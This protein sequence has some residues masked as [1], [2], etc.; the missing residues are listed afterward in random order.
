MNKKYYPI[1]ICS[2]AIS[3]ILG[4]THILDNKGIPLE[5]FQ[6]KNGQYFPEKVENFFTSTKLYYKDYPTL[7]EASSELRIIEVKKLVENK[8]NFNESNLSWSADGLYLGYEVTSNT[9]R[10][11]LLKD[12]SGNFQETLFIMPKKKNSFLDGILEKSIQ[13][14][15]ASLKWSKDSTRFAFMSNGGTGEYNIYVG[16]VGVK[17]DIIAKSPTKEG[18]PSW[19]PVRNEIAFVSSRSGNGD[20]YNISLDSGKVHRLSF[21]DEVDI[22]PEW[23]PDGNKVIY[24]SGESLNHDLKVSVYDQ[25]NN[26]WK[27]PIKLTN[28]EGD[29]LR[30]TISPDGR[31]IAFYSSGDRSQNN[32]KQWNIYVVPF[33][34]RPYTKLELDKMVVAKNV[35]VDL[36]T[37]PAW[38]PDSKKIFYV[39]KNPLKFNPIF[40][41]DLYTGKRFL[42]D[43]KTKMNR[44]LL[45]SRIGIISFRA[46][47]G[48]WDK[49]FIALTNQGLQLQ[50]ASKLESKIH[51]LN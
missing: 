44:D 50:T 34:E 6:A 46:Q 38:T 14:Y 3:L 5:N 51:Y 28:W 47:V 40:G 26:A 41:V 23:F 43:T 18:Y 27:A 1:I 31:L 21:G 7:A 48:A 15:N 30:P 16:A 25:E 24:S 19:N 32:D 36:N 17:E 20:I 2:F 12:I 9:K 33:R 29:D 45:V 22:F 8:T 37:G 4:C 49:V 39:E 10:N 35:V 42:L 11:I 13:S